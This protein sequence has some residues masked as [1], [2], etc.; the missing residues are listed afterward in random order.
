MCGDRVYGRARGGEDD[1]FGAV[2]RMEVV[3]LGGKS[4]GSGHPRPSPVALVARSRADRTRTSYEQTDVNSRYD[5]LDGLT[6]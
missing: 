2:V 3:D 1:V 5:S 4:F 6:A